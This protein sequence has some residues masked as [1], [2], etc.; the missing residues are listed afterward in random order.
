MQK[1]LWWLRKG[2]LLRGWHHNPGRDD[3]LLYFGGNAESVQHS[4]RELAAWF[5]HPDGRSARVVWGSMYPMARDALLADLTRARTAQ[6]RALIA[7]RT[8]R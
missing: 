8:P 6:L 5:P 2:L 4:A 1:P 3:V 7:E